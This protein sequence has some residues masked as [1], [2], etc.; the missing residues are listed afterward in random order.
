LLSIQTFYKLKLPSWDGVVDP[1]AAG[2]A[3]YHEL[4][5]QIPIDNLV[6]DVDYSRFM[7]ELLPVRRVYSTFTNLGKAYDM[8][9]QSNAVAMQAK[10]QVGILPYMNLLYLDKE[11]GNL[12][13]I[14]NLVIND[15]GRIPPHRRKNAV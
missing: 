6:T 15:S 9:W 13:V 7:D 4:L 8:M 11:D 2:E 10:V 1:I 14:N 5:D 12:C 3:Q